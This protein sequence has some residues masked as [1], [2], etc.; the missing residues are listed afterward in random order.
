MLGFQR[1]TLSTKLSGRCR[2]PTTP[3]RG[4]IW[5]VDTTAFFASKW[6]PSAVYTPTARPPSTRIRWTDFEVMTVPPAS[7]ITAA[8]AR[9]SRIDPPP[10]VVHVERGRPAL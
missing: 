2:S 6:E 7:A 10:G 4:L 5:I 9:G 8:L 3:G 1:P